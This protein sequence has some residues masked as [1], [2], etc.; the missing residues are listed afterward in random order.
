METDCRIC[1]K[2]PG[3][4]NIF[5]DEFLFDSEPP[6][7]TKIYIILNNFLHEKVIKVACNQSTLFFLI[8]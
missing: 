5:T 8:R 4:Y 2:E 1:F 3:V 6:R 7:Q